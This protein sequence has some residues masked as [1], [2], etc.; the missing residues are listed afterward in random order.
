MTK[1]A[2]VP[3]FRNFRA[4]EEI[5]TKELLD[6]I[7]E[8]FTNTLNLRSWKRNNYQPSNPLEIKL[9][10]HLSSNFKILG[11][12]DIQIIKE[13]K[14]MKQHAIRGFAKKLTEN[15][16]QLPKHTAK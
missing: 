15:F 3:V 4:Q 11:S 14:Q 7:N 6:M 8:P 2:D 12:Q 1:K 13:L 5:L 16:I 10:K 9:L